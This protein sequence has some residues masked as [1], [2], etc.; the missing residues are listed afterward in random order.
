MPIRHKDHFETDEL[1]NVT[2]NCLRNALPP[3]PRRG[4]QHARGSNLSPRCSG[5]CPNS[6]PPKYAV[7]YLD[8]VNPRPERLE[9][10]ENLRKQAEHEL[11]RAIDIV[12][13]RPHNR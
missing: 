1:E 6:L 8:K 5:D 12:I 7:S 2:E 10:L 13:E 4:C 11:R 9:M 3:D